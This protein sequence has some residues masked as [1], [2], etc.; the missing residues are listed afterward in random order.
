MINVSDNLKDLNIRKALD[1]TLS[2]ASPENN[3]MYMTMAL[4]QMNGKHP[5]IETL[6]IINAIPFHDLG[7]V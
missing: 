6:N 5:F 7:K 3:R 4:D 2:Q 1:L